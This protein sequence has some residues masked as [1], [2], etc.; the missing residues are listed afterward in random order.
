MDNDISAP[1]QTSCDI[2]GHVVRSV[3]MGMDMQDL[4]LGRGCCP[5]EVVQGSVLQIC[6]Y[7]LP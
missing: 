5:F 6:V 3:A 1:S 2:I 7:L 4:G